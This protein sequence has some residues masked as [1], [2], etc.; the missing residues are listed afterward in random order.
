MGL[1]LAQ[2][3]LA[4]QAG[5][6][7]VGAVVV[8]N[9][10]LVASGRNAPVANHDPSA[11]AEIVALRSAGLALNNY[12]LEG[13]E[14]YVTLEPCA[15]C[16]GAILQARISQV[17]Y[18][19]ADAKTG[20][21]GSVLN[22]FSHAGL[23]HQTAVQGGLMAE[24]S[25][26]LLKDFFK[27]L[28]VKVWPIRDDALRVPLKAISELGLPLSMSRYVNDLP[29]LRGLRM[30]WFESAKVAGS[31][32]VVIA[33]HGPRDWSA[34]YLPDLV[35]GEVALAPDLPGFGLSDKPKKETAH[36]LQWHASILAEW[37]LHLGLAGQ[38]PRV[39]WRVPPDMA[40]LMAVLQTRLGYLLAI[41]WDDRLSMASP[42]QS[43][44]YPDK[45]HLAGPIAWRRLMDN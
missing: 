43:A 1:A 15:M 18:G 39:R 7:P 12:R 37:L 6:V 27:P 5:E 42:L 20:A 3:R 22:L 21:A 45:G 28:R 25:K 40:P 41:D 26:T 17:V 33:L 31:G 19:A 14:M 29:S 36:S 35:A 44:P 10:A 2:A 9:G 4:A 30:H 13:C 24:A 8:K 11:H 16:S 23:N 34:R 38:A 32:D